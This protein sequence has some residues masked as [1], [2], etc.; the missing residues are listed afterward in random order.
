MSNGVVQPLANANL[1]AQQ[2]LSSAYWTKTGYLV[3]TPPGTINEIAGGNPAHSY[4]MAATLPRPVGSGVFEH[5]VDLKKIGTDQR[6]LAVGLFSRGLASG[7][8][9]FFDVLNGT[10]S[11]AQ[12]YGGFSVP[13]TILLAQPG[14]VW[15]CGIVTDC[16]GSTA[17]GIIVLDQDTNPEGTYSYMGVVTDGYVVSNLTLYDLTPPVGEFATPV[18][19]M[20]TNNATTLAGPTMPYVR[21]T[22]GP[23]FAGPATPVAQVLPGRPMLPGK[24]TPIQIVT[25]RPVLPGKATPIA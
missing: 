14:G 10:V 23:V 17:D 9:A 11:A 3:T 22:G 25:G 18:V 7:A 19:I 2:D 15:R 13:E 21:V 20:P 5:T 24:V 6:W 4:G 1:I 16:S 8:V 12:S